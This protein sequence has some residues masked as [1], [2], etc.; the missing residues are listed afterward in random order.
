[1]PWFKA[2]SKN[3]R[4]NREEVLDV[5]LR[6]DQVRANRVRTLSIALGVSFGTLLGLFIAWRAGQ[7]ALDRLV[8]ENSAFAIRNVEAQTDGVIR[9]DQIRRWAA[10][11]AGQNLLALDLSR[12]KRDIELC[13][14]V[15]SAAIERVLPDT[16]R[17]RV[18]EHEP[19]ARVHTM[20]PR[21]DGKGIMPVLYHIDA[22]GHIFVPLPAAQVTTPPDA[23]ELPLLVGVPQTDLRPG[24]PSETP[25]VQAALELIREFDNSPMAGLVSLKQI[26]CSSA[27]VVNVI[28]GQGSEVTFSIRQLDLQMR[29]WRA[30][31][32]FGQRQNRAIAA[33]DL[34]VGEN[35]PARWLETTPVPPASKPKSTSRPKKKNA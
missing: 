21:P 27:E 29:R 31:Y 5:K 17:I 11:R 35:I 32:D 9:L 16:L 33:V 22:L 15:Q 34:S 6:S 10:I 30:L 19:I 25:Q 24:H 3:R 18:F 28:T 13:S 2:K 8:F 4:L 23:I 14:T 20:L 1:M 12:V 26:D 7:W